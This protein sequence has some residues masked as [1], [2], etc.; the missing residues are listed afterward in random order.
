MFWLRRPRRIQAPRDLSDLDP[1]RLP[2][3]RASELLDI[4]RQHNR[5][6]FI[7]RLV[8]IEP[9]GFES[10][11]QPALE[12]F[13]ESAQLQPASAVDHH[14]GLGGLVVHTLEVIETALRRRKGAS[15][16]LNAGS[17][18]GR[19]LKEEQIWTYA[20]FA[21]AL[22]HDA[23]KMLTLTRLYLD[24]RRPWTPH[25]PEILETGADSYRIEFIQTPYQLQTRVNNS[26]FHILPAAGRDFLAQNSEVMTQLTAWLYG[27]SYEWGAIGD[28]VRQADGE[29]VAENRR[30]GGERDR[31]PNA[32]T[33]PLVERMMR[34]LR[35]CIYDGELK[36][37]RS[38]AAGWVEGEYTYM[39]CAVAASRVIERLRQE[40]STDIPSDN[41]RLFDIWQDHG[42]V[43]PTEDGRAVWNITVKGA[44]YQ[45]DLSM[46]KFETSRLFHPSRRPERFTGSLTLRDGP[47]ETPA[48]APEITP[49]GTEYE[50]LPQTAAEPAQPE[51]APGET[52]DSART[53]R[54]D[55]NESDK[56]R[57]PGKKSEE[58]SKSSPSL[59]D[60]ET[61]AHFLAWL[62]AGLRDNGLKV[63][64]KD[65]MVHIVPEG[66]LLITPA[67]FKAYLQHYGKA[68]TDQEELDKQFRRV[69]ARVQ[70]LRLHRRTMRKQ[71]IFKYKIEGP[72]FSSSIRGWLFPASTLYGE[73]TPP[74]PNELL[75]IVSELDPST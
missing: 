6:R 11:Y 12:R 42:Y 41:V 15:L 3:L 9:A 7:R 24:G 28:L 43:I 53:S 67:I 40:G 52:G 60:P 5:F 35:Q 63:N 54:T 66:V 38:G 13:I 51:A 62:R 32:P 25:G 16:P 58:T 65:A 20:V 21:G 46:L 74:E 29:S 8:S 73:L 22:L 30:S 64:R 49:A 48:P 68:S 56:T 55:T 2:I 47:A 10:L 72:N 57:E 39:V 17:D 59:D 1:D 70:K 50:E 27:D 36:F 31:L 71:N 14:C 44:D 19:I 45:H 4:L 69:Q 18:P 26:L 61:G 75:E 23:G 37:N 34:A 33:A